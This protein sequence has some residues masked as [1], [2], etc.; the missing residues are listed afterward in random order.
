MKAFKYGTREGMERSG[1]KQTWDH[2]FASSFKFVLV[3]CRWATIFSA[4]IFVDAIRTFSFLWG[5][6][7]DG[8]KKAKIR[9]ITYDQP[10][11]HSN[12]A[13]Q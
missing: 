11:A 10:E 13:L 9:L 12:G 5:N 3:G 8:A 2:F 4:H 1:L 7:H 6:D